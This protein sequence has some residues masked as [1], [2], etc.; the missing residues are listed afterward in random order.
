MIA[1]IGTAPRA[2][3]AVVV[4]NY[5]AGSILADSVAAALS[6]DPVSEVIV[7]DNG[8]ADDSLETLHQAC[9]ADQR[10]VI[11]HNGANLGFAQA[12]N[13]AIRQTS[14]PYVLLLNPDCI[15]PP[16]TLEHLLSVIEAQPEV[17]LLG[18]RVVNPGGSEQVAS[19]RSLPDPW[20]AIVQLTGLHRLN[21]RVGA[22]TNRIN[23][24]LPSAPVPVE[25]ISGAF[26][27][28]RRAAVDEVGGLDEGYFLHCED[29]DWFVRFSRSGWI[30]LFVPEVA[31]VH[32]KGACSQ[33]RLRRVEWHKHR[34]MA[35]FFRKFQ[36]DAHA[37]PFSL[38][39]L[40]GIWLHFALVM[41]TLS[42]RP[43]RRLAAADA[44]KSGAQR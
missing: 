32:Y 28:A 7:S 40:A 21:G 3:L 33:S 18:C 26:M 20:S 8:S 19:R 2:T 30:I 25:A 41:L 24:P 44:S 35:R 5:N 23:A 1:P 36:F 42:L 13:R 38:L 27:L 22:G 39:V 9:G 16:G 15:V 4:V 17:G 6:S 29:L 43:V 34:G 12:N 31:V 14:A 10:L 11:L 37:L